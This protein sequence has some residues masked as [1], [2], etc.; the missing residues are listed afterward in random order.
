MDANGQNGS[1]PCPVCQV[2]R[3]VSLLGAA[4]FGVWMF[5]SL[6]FAGG[7]TAVNGR[8]VGDKYWIGGH[9]LYEQVSKTTYNMMLLS[10]VIVIAMFF[11]AFICTG[12]FN[13]RQRCKS[14]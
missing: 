8:A 11:M 2:T 13:L 4:I 3:V 7:L 1:V 14:D 12:V 9:G 6:V 5:A 10:E